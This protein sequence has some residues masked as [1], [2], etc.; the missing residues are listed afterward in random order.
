MHKRIGLVAAGLA[1]AV[2]MVG[3]TAFAVSASIPDTSGVIHGC[4]SAGDAG[5]TNGTELLIIDSSKA[6][7]SKGMTAI[8]WSQKGPQGPQGA[9]GKDG[10][11]VVTSSGAPSGSCTTGNTDI[12][13]ANGEVYT[14]TASAWADTGSSVQGPQGKQGPAGT[15]AGPEFT[16]TFKCASGSCANENDAATSVP[17][18][19]LTPVSIAETGGAC[20]DGPNGGTVYDSAMNPIGFVNWGGFVGYSAS[21]SGPDTIS[22][23]GPLKIFASDQCGTAFTITFTFDV[24]QAYS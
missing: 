6:S 18:G 1:A 21:V 15:N 16:W 22:S 13:L 23:A 8:T 14:C 10:S 3:G 17:A 20:S 11:S 4:Y 12:D 19:V 24:T 9:A 2:V 7:C 5:Q